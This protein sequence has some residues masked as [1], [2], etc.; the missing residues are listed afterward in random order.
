MNHLIF[1]LLHSLFCPTSSPPLH[2]PSFFLFLLSFQG[3]PGEVMPLSNYF[4][5]FYDQVS[6]RKLKPYYNSPLW[7]QLLVINILLYLF[8]PIS[9]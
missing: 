8:K 7:Q 4:S 6:N 9:L 3:M 1:S 5:V 2:F